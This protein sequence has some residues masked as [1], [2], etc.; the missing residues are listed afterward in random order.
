MKPMEI[1][2]MIPPQ[3]IEVE[4]IVI[5]GLMTESGAFHK[6]ST[7]INEES[8]Y[9][10][11]YGKIF[12]A[13]KALAQRGVPTDATMT[14]QELKKTGELESV[15]GVYAITHISGKAVFTYN[16]EHHARIVAQ[17]FIQREFI[18]IGRETVTLGFDDSE[19]IEDQLTELKNKINEIENIAISTHSGKTQMSV[20]TAAIQEM[21]VD[22]Q[23]YQSG[24]PAG[25]ATGLS[26]L[27]GVIGGW[28]ATN[29]IIVAARPGVGKT[30]LAL[31]FAKT[32]AKSGHWVNFYGLEMTSEDLMRIQIS[33]ESGVNR[34]DVRD[35]R[36][37][38]QEWNDINRVS[39]MIEKLPIIW[40]DNAGIT[41]AQINANT[42]K[43][44]KRCK[45]DMVIIDYLQLM[46]PT[47][48][49]A[50]REQQISEI[51]R[52]LKR[53]ALE[54]KVPIICLSQLN[55]EASETKPQLHHLRESGAIE[56]DA[57]VVVFPWKDSEEKYQIIVA[58]NRR[59][60]T[61]MFEISVNSEMTRFE[62][63]AHTISK[64]PVAAKSPNNR[65]ESTEDIPF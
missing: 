46:A 55:R 53:T 40:Y 9:K 48:K 51:T 31:H 21:E 6:I 2:G 33:S 5:A 20:L 45:C 61:A 37:G 59:G 28:K 13:I 35:G 60:Q 16:I 7:I 22:C 58:K 56:Q 18:R 65:I 52:T 43:N 10:D 1:D 39:G 32:A 11:E 49:K 57:D 42:R 63:M 30:S 24:K 25:I 23:N 12:K 17:K 29:L 44:V 64:Q 3:A 41:S 14:T 4:E 62:N 47:D 19:D 38:D 50:I 34:V 15:G 8:F 36:L 54:M 26:A 27:N